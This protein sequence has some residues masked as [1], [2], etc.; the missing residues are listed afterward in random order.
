MY[1]VEL[2]IKKEDW[3]FIVFVGLLF[4]A[5]VSALGYSL[6]DKKLLDGALFGGILGVLIALFSLFFISFS[7]SYVLP[8]LPR[9]YWRTSSMFFSFLSGFLG[10]ICAIK[11]SE[12]IGLNL[13]DAF[14][15]KMFELATVIG[16]L[17]YIIGI[18]LHEFVKMRNENEKTEELLM[19]SR[20]SS[21]ETQLNPHFLFNSINSIAELIY[22]EP[23]KAEE[24]LLS[25]SD[26]LRA[27]MKESSL[28]TIKEELGNIQQYVALENIRFDNRIKV[29]IYINDDITDF[30]TPKFSI[31]LIVENAIKHGLEPHKT[32]N[33]AINIF[34]S[35]E[36][37]E[38]R[39]ENDGKELK[40]KTFGIGLKNLSERLKYLCDGNLEIGCEEK[41]EYIIKLKKAVDENTY[42]RR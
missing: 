5:L 38:I 21:L 35:S 3:L 22:K 36:T 23:S 4:G 16:L 29:N 32:L 26:F 34:R 9:L 42:C 31:G 19:Q 10:A 20:I 11:T 30:L 2:R 14:T 15:Q 28:I 37:I 40:S 12:L 13:L 17:T 8:K 24:A 1:D 41:K 25:I 18:L 33:I 39:V 27:V 7:N 6:F